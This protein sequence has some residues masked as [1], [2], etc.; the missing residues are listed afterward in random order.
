MLECSSSRSRARLIKI[1]EPKLCWP[2]CPSTVKPKNPTTQHP[3]RPKTLSHPESESPAGVQGLCQVATASA[4]R[5]RSR[6]PPGRPG[7]EARQVDVH[8]GI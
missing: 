3:K 5:R 7:G 4:E 6:W 2:R 1:H 8:I